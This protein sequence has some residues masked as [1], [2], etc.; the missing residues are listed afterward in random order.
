MRASALSVIAVLAMAA[1]PAAAS[2]TETVI[3]DGMTIVYDTYTLDSD[4]TTYAP[5]MVETS[6]T[7]QADEIVY[8]T[9]GDA[10]GYTHSGD[11]QSTEIEYTTETVPDAP[12]IYDEPATVVYETAGYGTDPDQHGQSMMTEVIDGII[13]ETVFDAHSSVVDPVGTVTTY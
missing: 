2:S 11:G 9:E 10:V 7:M 3:Q 5:D 1:L 4:G 13:Y 8:V 6:G 12:M